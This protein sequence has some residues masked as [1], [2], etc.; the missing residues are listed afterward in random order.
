MGKTLIPIT[1]KPSYNLKSNY[2]EGLY[3]SKLKP[4]ITAFF[5]QTL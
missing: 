2:S 1:L 5:I 4:K 3:E